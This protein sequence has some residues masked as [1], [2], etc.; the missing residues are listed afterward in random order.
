MNAAAIEVNFDGLVGPTHNY[1]GLSRGNL[2]S[3]GN[4]AR[5]SNPKEAA[6]QG[7]RKM[8]LV[9]SLGLPQG[10]LPPLERPNLRALAALGFRGSDSERLATAARQAPEVLAACCSAS[11][12]WTANAA[13]VSPSPDTQDGRVHFTPANLLAHLHRSL[14]ARETTAILRTIF[15]DPA[16]FEVHDPLPA[17]APLGDEGAANHTRFCTDFGHRGLELFVH[18]RASETT[19]EE[20]PGRFP[21]R[22]TREA[23]EAVRRLH[24]VP[25]A[26]CIHLRQSPASID[27]G[28]F[29]NDVIAVGHR[30]FHLFH[31]DAFADSDA[32]S[33]LAQ[34]FSAVTGSRLRSRPVL[35]EELRIEE[36]VSSYLFN[37]QIL[38]PESAE[39]WV[40]LCPIECVEQRATANLLNR[41]VQE[42]DVPVRRI[43]PVDLR[44]SMANGGGPACLRLRVV[45]NAAEREAL[46]ARVLLDDALFSE[47]ESWVIRHYRD[48][49]VPAD[50]A[51]PHLLEESRR[52]LDELTN[53][54]QTGPIYDFQK[55]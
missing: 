7:L 44:Q 48:S 28:V 12:M 43:L 38:S 22:Q 3:I 24:G 45:L 46:G 2:A 33:R 9:R 17:C 50:L 4:R 8:R 31:Q 16:H 6:L 39:G 51:D 40:L 18:G 29:H 20:G 37:S 55:T 42:P 14:E 23:G 52:A 11:S 26:N 47:L 13:T 19:V 41:L 27:A 49:L 10:L 30:D 35:R 21:A 1:A 15:S 54:L 25:E 53:I 34:Q 32:E 5:K 36:A